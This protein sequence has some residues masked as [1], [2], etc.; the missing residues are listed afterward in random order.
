IYILLQYFVFIQII[1]ITFKL[2]NLPYN[3]KD[4]ERYSKKIYALLTLVEKFMA[5]EY[6]AY[7]I[8]YT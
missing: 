4:K 7:E 1:P 6:M 3:K 8:H 2:I 5:I